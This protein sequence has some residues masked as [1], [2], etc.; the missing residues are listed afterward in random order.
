MSEIAL[1]IDALAYGGDGVGR[2]PD[3]RVVFVPLAAPGDLLRARLVEEEGRS[4]RAEI[5]EVLE[6]GPARRAP[7]C[8]L[9][10]RCGGCQL[11]HVE[12]AAQRS[13]KR[14]QV[15]DLLAR[16]GGV[17]RPPVGETVAAPEPFGY[18]RRVKLHVVRREGLPVFGFYA[19]GSRRLLEVERCP[20][21]AAPLNDAF[22]G[23]AAAIRAEPDL[24]A[25][26]SG[27]TLTACEEGTL[28]ALDLPAPLS[29]A[30][31]AAASRALL[32]APGVLGGLLGRRP[33]GDAAGTV[34]E[35][36]EPL[37]VGARSFVQVHGAMN[38]ALRRALVERLAP[39]PGERIADLFA[40][41]GNLAL[42]L[43][44][45]GAAVTAVESDADAFA[46]LREAARAAAPLRLECVRRDAKA[47]LREAA[48]A[49]ARYETVVLDPPRPGAKGFAPLLAAVGA[50]RA[51]YVS[52]DPAT[53]SRDVAAL[54]LEGFR[55][56][57]TLPFDFFPQTYHVETLSILRRG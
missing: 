29:E 26:L 36:G 30:D 4:A 42:A 41:G 8:P 47:W 5:L 1:R 23:L 22:A 3:G 34:L 21:L 27:L 31:A 52:C 15:A 7:P 17:Q 12:D 33:F 46:D 38:A 2:A 20:L 54:A 40:G 18:R 16:I 48:E 25:G 55:L 6:P 45:A 51:A 24:F 19:R 53:L 56:E 11:Q 10:G 43:A 49:G 44:R 50:R 28:A 35:R 57:S 32:A 39:R 9:Y 13:E 14:R 37:R